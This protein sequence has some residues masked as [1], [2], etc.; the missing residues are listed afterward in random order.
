MNTRKYCVVT[1]NH[2][3]GAADTLLEALHNARLTQDTA[4]DF[5]A[6]RLQD[7]D[8]L[9]EVSREW[10]DWGKDETEFPRRKDESTDCVIYLLDDREKFEGFD[11]SPFD[12]GVSV[13]FVE[14]KYTKEERLGILDDHVVKAT[15]NNGVLSPR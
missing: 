3:W 8:H 6:E 11:V 7:G 15:W 4:E 10:R 5:F 1:E 2:S 12:G 9:K 13:Y 14:G